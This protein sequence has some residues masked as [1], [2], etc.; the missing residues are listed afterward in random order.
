MD[1]SVEEQCWDGE[2]EEEEFSPISLSL[3]SVLGYDEHDTDMVNASPS[4]TQ[5]SPLQP[6]HK[7]G[8]TSPVTQVGSLLLSVVESDVLGL[9]YVPCR[10][11]SSQRW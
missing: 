4:V 6:T 3:E 10:N 11:E 8:A 2:E 1:E 9:N 5:T 7:R